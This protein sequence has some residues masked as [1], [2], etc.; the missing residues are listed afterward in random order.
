MRI[1]KRLLH[2]IKFKYTPCENCRYLCET[3][4]ISTEPG[5]C[6]FCGEPNYPLWHISNM[7]RIDR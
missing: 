3:T 2:N 1:N 7:W 4:I 5:E 6:Y